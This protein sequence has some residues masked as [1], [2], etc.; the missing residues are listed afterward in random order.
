MH[1]WGPNIQSEDSDESKFSSEC[2]AELSWSDLKDAHLARAGVEEIG[3]FYVPR[4]DP[5]AFGL[6]LKEY[7]EILIEEAA[8]VWANATDP[9]A[10]IDEV[11]LKELTVALFQLTPDQLEACQAHSHQ[12]LFQ[13]VKADIREL[14]NVVLADHLL[15]EPPAP[16]LVPD[17][18]Y[19]S[20]PLVDFKALNEMT[21]SA[22]DE[23]LSKPAFEMYCKYVGA[24]MGYLWMQSGKGW[25]SVTELID[26]KD[27]QA[28]IAA[29]SVD[30][31]TGDFLLFT[32]D[33]VYVPS[34]DGL[35]VEAERMI[36]ETANQIFDFEIQMAPIRFHFRWADPVLQELALKVVP[37]LAAL[38]E[39]T[40]QL[41]DL[42]A[43]VQSLREEADVMISEAKSK[44]EQAQQSLTEWQASLA[45]PEPQQYGVSPTG[46]EHWVRD[47]MLHMGA[48]N[49]VVTQQ[50]NDGGI[51][52]TSDL[53]VAQ[54]KHYQGSVGIAELRQLAG[55]L[56]AEGA[57]RHA[58]FFTSGNYPAQ[59]N[60]FADS[61]NMALF[62]YDV[63]SGEVSPQNFLA[64]RY[65]ERGFLS[66]DQSQSS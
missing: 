60:D 48:M 28:L 56:H 51:D 15:D 58:L 59:A 27:S 49:A 3:T 40:Q 54:V 46:A 62:V 23:T 64:K 57:Q 44:T 7:L 20:K 4:F 12:R 43:E 17:I 35:K 11:I 66:L 16:E 13:Q 63:T 33:D 19:S 42:E 55:V 31:S 21:G 52:I 18:V 37:N 14:K 22:P 47:W 24:Q 38:S 26:F 9:M 30:V 32:D 6:E 65:F 53:F 61:V 45:A 34:L 2:R 36:R 5:N 1:F 10:Q 25:L 29:Q 39:A 41:R 8:W 50:S